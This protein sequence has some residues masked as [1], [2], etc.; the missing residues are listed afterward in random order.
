MV[1]RA[2]WHGAE[3]ASG[4][5]GLMRLPR[6]DAKRNG[7]DG[8]PAWCPVSCG[9][10]LSAGACPP[11]SQFL[12]P[13]KGLWSLAPRPA[14]QGHAQ[15]PGLGE[16]CPAGFLAYSPDP[17]RSG[18]LFTKLVPKDCKARLS[19]RGP[20]WL[21]EAPRLSSNALRLAGLQDEHLE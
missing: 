9:S 11:T 1:T 3:T 5:R 7:P 21:P 15:L 8:K 18:F 14:S 10:P 13:Y 16:H 20:G 19:E 17:P 4:G 2:F 12:K 6:F